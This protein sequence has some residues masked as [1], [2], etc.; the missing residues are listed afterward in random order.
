MQYGGFA[1]TQVGGFW[2]FK[3]KGTTVTC[4]LGMYSQLANVA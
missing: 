3:S 2:P 1:A 4:Q